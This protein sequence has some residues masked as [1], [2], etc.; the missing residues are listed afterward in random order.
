MLSGKPAC[1][2][3]EANWTLQAATALPQELLSVKGGRGLEHHLPHLYSQVGLGD[4]VTVEVQRE[5]V[6]LVDVV[7]GGAGVVVGFDVVEQLVDLEV[8]EVV[9]VD[10]ED[11]EVVVQVV[12][13]DDEDDVPE[14]VGVLVG[15]EVDDEDDGGGALQGSEDSRSVATYRFRVALPPQV[16]AE[17]PVQGTLHELAGKDAVPLPNTTPQ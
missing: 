9:R 17:L 5:A 7:V 15:A 6:V 2:K 12:L 10:E 11:V 14:L 13:L 8:V 4:I 16:S 3:Q 1:T